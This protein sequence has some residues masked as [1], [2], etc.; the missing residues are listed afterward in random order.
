MSQKPSRSRGQLLRRLSYPIVLIAAFACNQ[1]VTQANTARGRRLPPQASSH[2]ESPSDVTFALVL[3]DTNGSG[4]LAPGTALPVYPHRTVVKAV[5]SGG[6]VTFNPISTDLGQPQTIGQGDNTALSVYYAFDGDVL[7]FGVN[8]RYFS[9]PS[10][11]RVTGFGRNPNAA[12]AFTGVVN[13]HFYDCGPSKP[14]LCATYSGNAG[15]LTLTRLDAELHF[16]ADSTTAA[17]GSV[18]TISALASPSIVDGQSMPVDVDSLKWT[19]DP[20]SDGGDST[21][22]AVDCWGN[23][24]HRTMKGGGTMF[25]VAYVN[26]KRQTGSVHIGSPILRVIGLPIAVKTG[27]SATFTASWSDGHT[28]TS[29]EFVDWHWTADV[30]PGQTQVCPNWQA[31]SPNPCTK[32]VMESGSMRIHVRRN[33]IEKYASAHVVVFTD[34]KLVADHSSVYPGDTVTYTPLYD[35]VPGVAE[36]WTWLPADTASADTQRCTDG[37][38]QCRRP[39][40]VTGRMWAYTSSTPNTGDSASADV[41]V[42]M[43]TVT[44]SVDRSEV[45]DGDTAVFTATITPARPWYHAVSWTWNAG[46]G[47]VVASLRPTDSPRFNRRGVATPARRNE[48]TPPDS[49]LPDSSVI[50]ADALPLDPIVQ[51]S[52]TTQP[53]VTASLVCAPEIY[54]TGTMTLVADVGG[55]RITSAPV[56]ASVEYFCPDQFPIEDVL[57]TGPPAVQ[58][59]PTDEYWARTGRPK[60][61]SMISVGGPYYLTKMIENPGWG[62]YGRANYR[63]TYAYD[64]DGYSML[65]S[66]GD[67]PL[68][69]TLMFVCRTWMSKNHR[70]TGSMIYD[71]HFTIHLMPHSP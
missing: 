35:G 39:M 54:G 52:R 33:G 36:R 61:K 26:G 43:P 5:A 10:G 53:C 22:L 41:T 63:P 19:P 40:V 49:S 56:R 4:H 24:C 12:P 47:G 44:L 48:L 23:P 45:G 27:H 21:D 37:T 70:L 17:P 30:P 2:D 13:G 6:I 59:S 25:V 15:A 65:F 14:T 11:T 60:G 46:A 42:A 57:S 34:F 38:S 51:D 69:S 58:I 28:I 29:G 66:V 55:R 16:V 32:P 8:P 62:R 3:N 64:E 1:D 18:V 50:A 31:P 7:K 9:F 71:E 20:V 67:T 68:T